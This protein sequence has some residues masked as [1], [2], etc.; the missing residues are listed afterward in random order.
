MDQR[1]TEAQ[2][3][4]PRMNAS[5]GA[6]L[7]GPRWRTVQER[8]PHLTHPR[9]LEVGVR[10]ELTTPVRNFGKVFGREPG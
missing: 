10:S 1:G 6:G 2:Q 5:C 8:T 4:T 3:C 7:P 9:P